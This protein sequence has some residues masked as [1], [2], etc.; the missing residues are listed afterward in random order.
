MLTDREMDRLLE[1]LGA[2]AEV[3]GDQLRPT[4]AALMAE[5]LAAYPLAVVD[6]ALAAC[7]RELKGRLSLAA[8]L[9]RIEDGHPSPNE[10]WALASP[11]AD[12]RNTVVWTQ[13]MEL[14][15]SVA[16]PLIDAG[17]KVAARMAFLERYAK[18]VKDAKAAL[19]PATYRPSLGFDAAGRDAA[20][21]EAV[22]RGLLS[23]EQAQQHLRIEGP[24]EPAFNPVALL[25]GKVEVSAAAPQD[26]RE[27]LA[28]LARELA[29]Q[30][31]QRQLHEDQAAER[32]RAELE[33]ARQRELAKL[34]EWVSEH[35][36]AE[37]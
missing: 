19:R 8:I 27:R 25:G 18:L 14:A 2:T 32:Q 22:S 3:I 36:G 1:L 24:A 29:D 6:K 33:A 7:R 4:A 12:E 5:E 15:W 26:M 37:K 23:R 9:E 34:E 21:R 30:A 11:A 31:K 13:E 20:L 28:G 16:L 35:G 17:D 10:A